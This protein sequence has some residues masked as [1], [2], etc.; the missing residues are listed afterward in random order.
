MRT[1]MLA[2][3]AIIFLE[4]FA[5]NGWAMQITDCVGRDV[6]ISSEVDHIISLNADAT[7]VL[8]SL[9]VGERIVGIDSSTKNDPMFNVTYPRLKDIE[10]VGS[11]FSGTLNV[12]RVVALKPDAILFGGSSKST[13]ETLQNQTGIPCA[14]SYVGVKK[15]DDFLCGYELIGKIVGRENSS[16]E[17]QSFIK[18]EIN[19]IIE[20]SSKIPDS[21]KPKVL[22]IGTP[23][24]KDPLKV[25]I[26]SGAIDWAGGINVA[27]EQYK[28]GSPSKTASMEQIAQWNPDIILISGLSLV[29]PEDIQGDPNWQQLE[30]VKNSK[31]YKIYSSTVGYDPAIFVIQALQM[32]KIMHPDKYDFDLAT[33]ADEVFDKIYGISGLHEIFSGQFGISKV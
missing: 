21:E 3:V 32:A 23:F 22:L 27:S 24:D 6:N 20:I 30:A 10:D 8:I 7:R 18:N 1:R 13:A 19:G 16:N 2:A 28:G 29:E 4:L 26:L 11:H 12:E 14:C 15:V 25:S 17:I 5:L 9:G 33:K 31:V